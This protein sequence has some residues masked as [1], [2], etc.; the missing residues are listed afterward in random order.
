[1]TAHSAVSLGAQN[2]WRIFQLMISTS[3]NDS[4]V[5]D[6]SGCG[7]DVSAIVGDHSDSIAHSPV[8][9][10]GWRGLLANL[11]IPLVVIVA[12]VGIGA[13]L[14]NSPPQVPKSEPEAL[15]PV[16][17]L[18]NL[19]AQD[20]QVFVDAYGTVRPAREI[21]IAPEVSG[22]II[23]LNPRLEP[24]GLILAGEE[25]FKIDPADYTIAVALAQA[26]LDV[27]EHETARIR[28]R[29]ETLRGRGRQLDVEI[30]YLKWNADRLGRLAERDSVAQLEAREAISRL[31]S[32]KAA[33]QSLSAEIVEQE[34]AVESAI[35]GARV[36][37]RRLESARLALER[38]R[39]I[40]P[41]DAI[42]VAENVEEGQLIQAQSPVATLAA[43]AEFWAEAAIP[44]SRLADVR[45][46]V[47]QP[48]DPSRVTVG[49]A[50]GG[51]TVKREG[52]A[53]RPLGNLDPLGRMAR[54]LVSIRDPLGLDESQ[55][56][57]ARRVLLGS[58]VRLRIESGTLRD[59]YSIPRKA[60]RENDRIWVRNA[61]GQLAIRPIKIVWRRHD[62]VL[63]RNG[64]ESGDELVTTHLASVVPGM[65]LRIREQPRETATA[66]TDPDVDGATP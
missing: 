9:P 30:D 27:A 54:V 56:D 4:G 62:D 48:D 6:E 29:I 61:Q 21:R 17:G 15:A 5:P 26:D 23:E 55:G 32:Q 18:S 3:H 19:V 37:E 10:S 60:L 46:A 20:A 13:A 11:A 34:K 58:Y 45:F 31:E 40:A 25:L 24:G 2:S 16:V 1:L 12:A 41:F 63:V 47:E 57:A 38:T 66:A 49:L 44:V 65:P 7:G 43:T 50:T 53:L 22:R 39:V 59:V 52:V 8:A 14:I 35:A 36:V 51:D 42:V 28:A 33:R 64:F